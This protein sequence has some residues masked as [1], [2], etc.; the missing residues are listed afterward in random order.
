MY[1]ALLP[2]SPWLFIRKAPP[3]A[4]INA[5]L[6]ARKYFGYFSCYLLQFCRQ[7]PK[8]TYKLFIDPPQYILASTANN[9]NI[10]DSS[11]VSLGRGLDNTDP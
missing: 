9:D 11:L 6:S 7:D 3:T 8:S 5:F 2:G 1:K 10:N 4:Y